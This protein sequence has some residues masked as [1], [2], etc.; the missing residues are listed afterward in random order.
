MKAL[1]TSLILAAF[2]LCVH[3]A[4][5]FVST[6]GSDAAA[7]NSANTPLA[8]IAKGVSAFKAGDTLT[9]LPGEYRESVEVRKLSGTKD[10]PV[11]IRAQREGTVLLRGD[12]EVAGWEAVKGL[13]GVFSAAFKDEA[14]GV[15]DPRTMTHFSPAA[16]KA[17]L[18]SKPG[19]FFQDVENGQLLVRTLDAQT[20]GVLRV[21]VTNGCGLALENCAHLIVE[22]LT[23]TG[24]QHRDNSAKFG[25]RTRWGLIASKSDAVTVRR[26]TAYLSSGGICVMN[27]SGSVVEECLAFGNTSRAVGVSNQII[28]WTAKD[29]VF[30]R[31]RI[32]GFNNPPG[33][34]D[35]ITFYSN[36]DQPNVLENNVAVR[37]SFMDK[38]DA[39][40]VRV[41]GNL[42]TGP[43]PEFYRPED[44]S[45]LRVF[46]N[47]PSRVAAHFADPV[48]DDF[49]L[50][51]DAPQRGK[52][53]AGADPGPNPYREEVFFVS[54]AGDDAAA[55]TSPKKPW[56]T[57]KHAA[58]KAKAGDT[59]YL[60]RGIYPEALAPAQSGA[61]GKAIRFA[62]YGDDRVILDGG[63][64]LPVAINLTGRSHI[65]VEGLVMRNFAQRGVSASDGSG[66]VLANLL[67]NS[68]GGDAVAAMRVKG[69]TLRH[70]LFVKVAEAGVRLENCGEVTLAGNVFGDCAT[71]R[72][73]CDAPSAK[74]LWSDRNNFTPAAGR[75]PLVAVA[76]TP[77]ATL[78]DWQRASGLDPHSLAVDPAFHAAASGGGMMLSDGSPLIGRGPLGAAIGPFRRI[79]LV[80]GVAVADIRLH[81]ATPT[82]ANL[83]C[84]TPAAPVPVKLEW[85]ET[86]ALGN[87]RESIAATSHTFSLSG[88][89]PGAAYHYRLSTNVRQPRNAFATDREALAAG[90]TVAAATALTFTTPAKSAPPRTLHVA[91]DGGDT[92]AGTTRETAW[93]TLAHAA[94]QVV[95]GDTVLVQ[96]GTYNEIIP[97]RASGDTG[98]PITFRTAPGA[99][100]WITGNDR[101]RSTAFLLKD[102][103]HIV[104]DGFRFRDFLSVDSNHERV[105]AIQ[106]GSNNTVRRCFYDGRVLIGYMNVFLG[107]NDSPDALVENCVMI[108]GMGEG[109]SLNT[110]PRSVVRHCVFYNNNIRALSIMSDTT[111]AQHD[112]VSITHNLFCA[113]I[114]GKGGSAFIRTRQLRNLVSDHNLYFDRFEDADRAIVE[115]SFIGEKEVREARSGRYSGSELSLGKL[116]AETGLEKNSRFGNPGL[117]VAAQLAPRYNKDHPENNERTWEA[118]WMTNDL[119]Q[120]RKEIQPLDFHHFIASPDSPLA[121]AA[122]GKPIGLDPAEFG[123]DFARAADRGAPAIS[124]PSPK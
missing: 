90:G 61:P 4:E 57:L 111:G 53:L 110:C 105:V 19:A 29:C 82:T 64:K 40:K 67:V 11:T 95:A 3:A 88:L 69:L 70:G 37:G 18:G 102:K 62:R 34:Q 92:R 32:E 36:A 55:G 28:G 52:G 9:I 114:P 71:V 51:P 7:G 109:M 16:T 15:A 45:N 21:S 72:I 31:N 106:G 78:A 38:G 116:R 39:S 101:T 56:K 113:V 76:Q 22:G 58:A 63:G 2:S 124:H 118:K 49:R 59:I 115:A 26:C 42:T 1:L 104:I 41:T 100:V 12:V 93:R 35:Q 77:Y 10:A 107:I 122:D 103:S 97:V 60:M 108:L 30:R 83:E 66:I 117:A 24:Y 80:A 91:P 48:N 17:E 5:Y 50:L 120:T 68:I 81:S 79:S 73:A 43:R 6:R 94:T 33:S 87:T 47:D 112:P 85:G 25:S 44:A 23:F 46:Y 123:T 74:S 65:E 14:H 20:P 8:T 13:D 54:P 121:K 84:T 86:T 27:S 75:G 96:A 98:E 89:K 99:V 119:H